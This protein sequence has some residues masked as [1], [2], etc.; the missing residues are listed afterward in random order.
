MS[1]RKRVQAV[2]PVEAAQPKPRGKPKRETAPTAPTAE[3]K[4]FDPVAAATKP[5][6]DIR[7]LKWHYAIPNDWRVGDVVQ[8][9]LALAETL[10]ANGIATHIN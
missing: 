2:E 3:D 4:A 7:L 9:E 6:V 1:K 8:C 10:V 5:L